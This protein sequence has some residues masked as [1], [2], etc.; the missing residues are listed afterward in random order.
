M[1]DRILSH[2]SFSHIVDVPIERIDIADW[3][4]NPGLSIFLGRVRKKAANTRRFARPSVSEFP[5]IEPKLPVSPEGLSRFPRKWW[6]CGV[7]KWRLVRYCTECSD[8]RV[9]W[10]CEGRL[11]AAQ[12]IRLLLVSLTHLKSF[13]LGPSLPP[14]DFGWL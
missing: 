7:K 11:R 14:S 9:H 1:T 6:F 12:L 8:S 2:S 13:G 10:A 3:L 4:F 5:G